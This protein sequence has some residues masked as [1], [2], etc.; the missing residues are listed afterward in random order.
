[1]EGIEKARKLIVTEIA[2]DFD[3]DA[4]FPAPDPEQWREI[5]RETHHTNPPNDFDFAFVTYERRA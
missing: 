1:V 4:T 5:S 2:A 3:G